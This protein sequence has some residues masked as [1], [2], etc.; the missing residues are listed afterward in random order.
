M[1]ICGHCPC[2]ADLN[3]LCCHVIS[4]LLFL[5]QYEQTGENVLALTCTE[6]LQ[7]WHKKRSKGSIPIE[8]LSQIKVVSDQRL[9]TKAKTDANN[10]SIA[11]DPGSGNSKRDVNKMAKNIRESAK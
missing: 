6:Q 2:P 10:Q 4:L 3:G 1:P 5:K 8:P 11:A 9:K 7:K